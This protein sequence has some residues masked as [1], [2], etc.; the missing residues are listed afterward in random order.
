MMRRGQ[1]KHKDMLNVFHTQ[2]CKGMS[3]FCW[4]RLNKTKKA[5]VRYKR[6]GKSGHTKT[7]RAR[8]KTNK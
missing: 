7:Q 1:G 2:D 3:M 6:R 5:E 4:S 8:K